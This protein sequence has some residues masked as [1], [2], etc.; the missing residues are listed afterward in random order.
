MKQP[1]RRFIQEY[2]KQQL[3]QHLY[4]P[5]FEEYLSV[6]ECSLNLNTFKKPEK[7]LR[8][9]AK[10]IIGPVVSK[11]F[12]VAYESKDVCWIFYDKLNALAEKI[13]I[14]R[15]CDANRNIKKSKSL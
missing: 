12:D 3:M 2:T 1:N 15:V 9:H 5:N 8:E 6:F 13:E 7:I 4:I 14:T 11:L 10:V